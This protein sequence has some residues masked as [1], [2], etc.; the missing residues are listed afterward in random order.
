MSEIQKLNEALNTYFRPQTFP[1]AV[2]LVSSAS[3]IPDKTRISKRDL[4]ITMPL[5]QGVSIARRQGWSLAMGKDDMLC[6]LGALTLGFLPA[7]DKF[8]DGSFNVPFWVKSQ[9]IRAKM[10]QSLAK[11]DFK[12]YS[13]IIMAPFHRADFTPDLAVIYGN[14]AQISRLV[15]SIVYATGEP[16]TSMSGGGFACGSEITVPILTNKCQVV[17][18]GG[19]DRAI[20]QTQDHEVAF[21]MPWAKADAIAEGLEGTHKAGMRYPTPSFLMYQAMFPPAFAEVTEYLAKDS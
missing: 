14:P 6:P 12:K 16:V 18:T 3:D 1:V 15:Q 10:C 20:A 9:E 19:G 11:L 13:H 7:K 2:K 17:V 21:A 5:C 4:G 8:M